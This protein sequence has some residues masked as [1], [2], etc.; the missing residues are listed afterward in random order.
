MCVAIVVLHQH[1]LLLLFLVIM[2]YCSPYFYWYV[3]LSFFKYL[4]N[5]LLFHN[6]SLLC[7]Y[8]SPSLSLWF[9]SFNL[10]L[11]ITFAFVQMRGKKHEAS[12]LKNFKVSFYIF[13]LFIYFS[14]CMYVLFVFYEHVCVLYVDNFKFVVCV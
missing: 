1:T 4:F 9:G 8:Y 13:L 5:L 7:Y 3:S 14:F 6:S 2:C 11:P 10:V 12:S